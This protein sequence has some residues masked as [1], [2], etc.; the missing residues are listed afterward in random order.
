[1]NLR[2]KLKLLTFIFI[3]LTSKTITVFAIPVR[4]HAFYGEVKIRGEAAPDGTVVEA[5]IDGIVYVATKTVEGKYGWEPTFKVP[6]DDKDTEEKDGGVNGDGV[7]FY[8]EGT[9]AAIYSFNN[10]EVTNLDLFVESIGP[11]P[12]QPPL[13]PLLSN[14]TATPTEIERGDNVTI[15][16]DIENIDSQSFTYIVTMKIGE[17][18]VLIDVELGAYES[19]TVS[20]KITQ[21]IT[22]DYIVT[23]DGLT[24]SFS[25]KT[26]P[27]PAEFEF[28]NLRIFYPGVAPPEVEAGQTVAV[29]VFIEAENVGELEGGR[30]V[31]LNVN[32]EVIDSKEVTLEG[33]A[34]ETVL[35]ELTRGE[36]RYEVEVEGF[37]E[38]FTVNIKPEPEPEPRS[39]PG[40]PYVSIILGLLIALVLHLRNQT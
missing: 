22:G 19:K 13:P 25:V 35:F 30:T 11:S 38:S 6:A 26:L 4:P 9:L 3:I 8:I 21:D 34:A 7:E 23:V 20:Q 14:L 27:E 36:G 33:G 15:S 18:T 24:G 1:M 2:Y 16:L 31:E 28:S 5:I 37:T 17:L 40:F 32:G 12:P 29:I 39:I 10:G